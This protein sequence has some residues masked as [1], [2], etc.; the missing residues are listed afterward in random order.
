MDGLTR[1]P[2]VIRAAVTRTINEFECILYST[3]ISPGTT[4]G[5]LLERLGKR[6]QTL[7]LKGKALKEIGNDIESVVDDEN[8][9]EQLESA[10][11]LEGFI[12]CMKAKLV[13]F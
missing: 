11:I 4:S 2:A 3:N 12:S 8:L 1:K 13:Q 9:V 7:R 6:F 10:D 5:A